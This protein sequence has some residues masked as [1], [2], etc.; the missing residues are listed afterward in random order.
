MN[1]YNLFCKMY[2]TKLLKRSYKM[3]RRKFKYL[4]W[5]AVALSVI[6]LVV[7]FCGLVYADRGITIEKDRMIWIN[8]GEI[9]HD[10]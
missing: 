3:E 10:I 1:S 2:E 6:F 8:K 5:L 9:I 4:F 7:C